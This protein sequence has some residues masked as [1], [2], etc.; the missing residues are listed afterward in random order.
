CGKVRATQDLVI[1]CTFNHE[2]SGGSF[3]KLEIGNIGMEKADNAF[4]FFPQSEENISSVFSKNAPGIASDESLMVGNFY[5]VYEAPIEAPSFGSR[6]FMNTSGD[7]AASPFGWHHDGT[8]P[9]AITRGNNVYAYEDKLGVNAG[10]SPVGGVPGGTLMFDFPVNF[11]Q[12]PGTYTNAAVTNL[13]FWNN[14]I[15]DVLWQYGFTA[16]AGNFQ[17]NNAGQGGVGADPVHAEAQDGGGMNNANFLTLPDG[18]PGRMQMYLWSSNAEAELVHINNSSSY[19]L[20]GVH[21]SGIPAAFGPAITTTGVTGQLVIVEA[22]QNMQVACTN[23]CGCGTGQGVGL[24]PNNNVQ[25]K[26]VL[27]DRGTCSFIEKV[28]GAQLGGLPQSVPGARGQ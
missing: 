15:H 10:T 20:G 7:P 21:F 19:P 8:I 13:F 12:Q 4:D 2:H 18:V 23:D 9:Y 14:H 6:T 16:P 24:P 1:K 5:R 28:M 27:I 11:N 17:F 22:N 25:G 26:I 3:S